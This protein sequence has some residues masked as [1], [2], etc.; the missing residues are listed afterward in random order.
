MTEGT[1][2]A[3]QT[4]AIHR[5]QSGKCKLPLHSWDA[6]VIAR[7]MAGVESFCTGWPSNMKRTAL[8]ESPCRLQYA[9]INLCI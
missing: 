7:T 2:E 1:R 4:H 8:E 3:E 9:L 5:H 6:P